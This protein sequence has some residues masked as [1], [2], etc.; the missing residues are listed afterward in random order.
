MR[1]WPP[2]AAASPARGFEGLAD[3]PLFAS[4]SRTAN[5]ENEVATRR[6][7]GTPG[8]R[9]LAAGI[10]HRCMAAAAGTARRYTRRAEPIRL[11]RRTTGGGHDRP[12]AP[13]Q[14]RDAGRDRRARHPRSRARPAG[15]GGAAPL[16]HRDRRFAGDCR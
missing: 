15:C 2:S 5:L 6:A 16:G 3:L 11:R 8:R 7:P 12:A 13:P 10:D 9:G 1:D 14:A 4:L